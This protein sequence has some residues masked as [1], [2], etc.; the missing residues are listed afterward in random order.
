MINSEIKLPRR[1]REKL[2]RRNEILEAA[3]KLFA[4]KGYDYTTL[5]EIAEKAEFGKGTI[6][7][8]FKSKEEIFHLIIE[9]IFEGHFNIL[10]EAIKNTNTFKDLVT[11][12][13]EDIF[14]FCLNN[15]EQFK[16]LVQVR[17]NNL[18]LGFKKCSDKC[19]YY[20]KEIFIMYKDVLV[21]SIKSG[22]IVDMDTDSLIIFYPS[23][24]FPYI[25]SLISFKGEENID[26][27]KEV[28]FL[29]N[30]IFNGILK[31]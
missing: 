7:N 24:V 26:I 21:K 15:K 16:I 8:Y 11:I 10:S 5:D 18:K 29:N 1:E 19:A 23:F 9:Q 25:V 20:D 6:Y 3:T 17:T 31:R 2:F 4:E 27:K 14:K 12:I 30:L 28:L 13:T 22:E